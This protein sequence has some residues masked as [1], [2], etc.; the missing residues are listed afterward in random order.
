MNVFLPSPIYL[1]L[2]APALLL[3]SCVVGPNHEPPN[4]SQQ[5]S[6]KWKWQESNPRDSHPRGEW[7]TLFNDSELNRIQKLATNNNQSIK[8]ALA[9]LDQARATLGI[10]KVAY[11]P[12][13]SFQ[14]SADRQRTSG[15]TASA[16]PIDIP[17]AQLNS[18]SAPLVLNYEVD[19]WGR[20]RRSV[21]SAQASAE[22][23]AADFHSVMLSVN[24]EV[25]STYYLIRGYD[26]ELHILESTIQTQK[27]SLDLIQQRFAAG[28]IP[29]T[30]LAKAR[31]ELANSEADKADVLRQREETVNALSILCGQSASSFKITQRELTGNPP[32]ISA[33]VPASLLERR[34]DVASAERK[35]AAA[36]ADI[37]VAIAG[38]FPSVSLTGKAGYTSGETSNLFDADSKV[39]S[40]GPSISLPITGAFV[41][42]AKVRRAKAAHEEAISSYRQTV[43]EAVKDVET[44]LVQIRYR[45]SQAESLKEVVSQ[46]SKA[47][48]LSRQRYE[49]GTVSYLEYLDAQ[50]SENSSKRTSAR[51]HAQEFVSTVGLIRALGGG[52]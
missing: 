29:E 26:A 43:L 19:L 1:T 31:S 8:G 6:A 52:W 21:E 45:R 41:N 10:S 39:W 37:G 2:F 15:N 51:V 42:Q 20:I 47:T 9:R 48:S 25:A 11:V 3:S 13:L 36:N 14:G 4:V 44:S 35:V 16:V 28:T 17:S 5:V 18:F 12:D 33:G 34:P 46:S 30:D 27:N 49:S 22:S 24:A 38:Y 32:R 7:W 40:I 50:R 23:Q